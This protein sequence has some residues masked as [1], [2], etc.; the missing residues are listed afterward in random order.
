MYANNS[1][2]IIVGMS[3]CFITFYAELFFNLLTCV[4]RYLPVVHRITYRGLKNTRGIRIRNITIGCFWMLCFGMVAMNR[5]IPF[6]YET[7]IN[8]SI[9]VSSILAISFSSVSVLCVLFP[10]GP[11]EGGQ[12]KYGL[13]KS[14]MK[15]FYTITVI[16]SVVWLWFLDLC[17]LVM[18]SRWTTSCCKTLLPVNTNIHK[19]S[20][21]KHTPVISNSAGAESTHRF[22]LGALSGN[23]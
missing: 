4:E 7:V 3:I 9:V 2:I 5:T 11:R 23:S 13:D 6:M 14:R 8:F 17:E 22:K 10:P 20:G 15:A 19:T 21:H 16:S 1:M 12:E 18:G